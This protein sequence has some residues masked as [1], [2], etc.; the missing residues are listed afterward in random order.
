MKFEICVRKSANSADS[1]SEII[2][3]S[4]VCN[5]LHGNA[6]HYDQIKDYAIAARVQH[7]SDGI[8]QI[9]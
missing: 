5:P 4:L 8:K 1:F 3:A 9:A 7:V 6:M 2:L